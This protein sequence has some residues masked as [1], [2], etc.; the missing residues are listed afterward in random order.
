MS[1]LAHDASQVAGEDRHLLL[2]DLHDQPFGPLLAL[3]QEQA[4]AGFAEG[5]DGE[6]VGTGEVSVV[7]HEIAS[8]DNVAVE[9]TH[10][11]TG[12]P[13]LKATALNEH[14]EMTVR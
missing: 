6:A 4:V 7:A 10:S 3:Q 2:L 9:L 13:P 5:A 14:G 1:E 8:S 11:T 12:V